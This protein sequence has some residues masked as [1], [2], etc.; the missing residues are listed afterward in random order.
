M[1]R[2]Q[3]IETLKESGLPYSFAY[4]FHFVLFGELCIKCLLFAKVNVEESIQTRE[5]P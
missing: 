2:H 1:E 3:G 5:V 4:L